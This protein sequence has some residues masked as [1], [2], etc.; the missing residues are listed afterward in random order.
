M[1]SIQNVKIINFIYKPFL[2]LFAVLIK[3]NSNLCANKFLCVACVYRFIIIIF[4]LLHCHNYI[5]IYIF[6][7][8]NATQQ[9]HKPKNRLL[10]L[11]QFS[12]WVSVRRL[13]LSFKKIVWRCRGVNYLLLVGKFI[14]IFV[15]IHSFITHWR[16][17][18]WRRSE[19]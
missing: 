19:I 14:G 3:V 11:L 4:F 5:H 1:C 12:S 18:A 13:R 10:F 2:F 9:W 15:A 7:E 16:E 17:D 6:W 8:I